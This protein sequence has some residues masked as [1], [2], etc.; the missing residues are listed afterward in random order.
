M[1]GCSGDDVA[2]Q[3][4]SA[5]PAGQKQRSRSRLPLALVA[6]NPLADSGGSSNSSEGMG[7]WG[8]GEQRRVSC[9]LGSDGRRSIGHAASSSPSAQF[10]QDDGINTT[11]HY[12][13]YNR[14][15]SSRTDDHPS[16]P[17]SARGGGGE[18]A[19]VTQPSS[20]RSGLGEDVFNQTWEL[21]STV[22]AV[23]TCR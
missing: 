5:R 2:N 6:Q 17:S 4:A 15:L 1:S 21:Q 8:E 19:P 10:E 11:F 18:E 22:L 16:R 14:R 20:L 3:Q 9:S 7:V 23:G 13:V 12:R